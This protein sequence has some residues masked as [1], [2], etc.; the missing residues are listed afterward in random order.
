MLPSSWMYR[1]ECQGYGVRETSYSPLCHS[2]SPRSQQATHSFQL[3]DSQGN[4]N[5]C[6]NADLHCFLHT[7]ELLGEF[8]TLHDLLYLWFDKDTGFQFSSDSL[9]KK[10]WRNLK[11]ADSQ[12]KAVTNCFMIPKCKFSGGN[13]TFQ[14]SISGSHV[15]LFLPMLNLACCGQS[16]LW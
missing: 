7:S 3:S 16:C 9:G 1:D 12:P 14:G 15:M 6:D 2:S 13:N 10:F 8:R 5:H 4:L 11:A